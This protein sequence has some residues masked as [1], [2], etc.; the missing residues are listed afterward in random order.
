MICTFKAIL[1]A[2]V[3]EKFQNMCLNIHEL[4]PTRFLKIHLQ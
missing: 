1:L 2:D 4:E 3:F